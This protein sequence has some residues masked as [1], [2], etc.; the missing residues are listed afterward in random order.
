MDSDDEPE[1]SHDIEAKQPEETDAKAVAKKKNAKSS[2]PKLKKTIKKTKEKSET[3]KKS[4]SQYQR[5][6]IK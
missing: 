6:N 4:K 3:K 2:E 5:R 1:E